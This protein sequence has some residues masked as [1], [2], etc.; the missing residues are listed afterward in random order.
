MSTF[1]VKAKV[2]YIYE[3]EVELDGKSFNNDEAADLVEFNVHPRTE[4]G[5]VTLRSIQFMSSE[6]IDV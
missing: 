2:E 6:R 1:K 5:S 3:G 4:E